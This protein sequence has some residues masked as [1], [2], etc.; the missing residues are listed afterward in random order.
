VT[1]VR[2]K[3][4]LKAISDLVGELSTGIRAAATITLAASILV[5]GGALAAGHHTRVYDAVIL[6]TLGATRRRLIF[7]YAL[8]YALLGLI[9]AAIATV[10]GTLAGAYVVKEVMR[11]SFVFAGTTALLAALFS[12]LLT[13]LF[14]LVGTW[15]ALGQKP[16]SVLRN[17]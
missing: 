11:F 16:A 10:A 6:K 2:V 14:G 5:L 1:A 17:L 3:E 9:T 12:V 7:V 4:A 8:E 13:V 15:R